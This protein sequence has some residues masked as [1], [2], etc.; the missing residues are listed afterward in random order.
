M[1]EYLKLFFIMFS[2]RLHSIKCTAIVEGTYQQVLD[3]SFVIYI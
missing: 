2:I 3:V 1:L